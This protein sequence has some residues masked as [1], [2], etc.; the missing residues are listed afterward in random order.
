MGVPSNAVQAN[1]VGAVSDDELNTFL[2]VV[3]IVASA[4]NFVGVTN[5]AIILLG[6]V[7]PGDGGLGTFYWNA[8]STAA[9]D[10]GVTTI[11]PNGVTLGAWLRDVPSEVTN[12]AL[13]NGQ[14]ITWS[15]NTDGT[16]GT[17]AYIISVVDSLSDLQA[18]LFQ[19]TGPTFL[20]ASG[21]AS[22]QI[23]SV[24]S[25]VDGIT[26]TPSV[27]GS[28]PSIGVSG[29]DT[30]I[31]LNLKTKGTAPI[32][33][34]AAIRPFSALTNV[35]IMQTNQ[36]L[37]WVNSNNQETAAISNSSVN[38]AIQPLLEFTDTGAYFQAS[39]GTM[40]AMQELAS[41]VNY[42][43]AEP[44]IT[45]GSVIL[46]AQG[47]DTNINVL[48]QTQG[49]GNFEWADGNGVVMA[50]TF[51]VASSVNHLVFKPAPTGISPSLFV[52]GSDTNVGM[53]IQIK[54]SS[55][56]NFQTETGTNLAAIGN[57]ASAVNNILLDPAATGNTPIVWAVGTDTNVGLGLNTKGS[58]QVTINNDGPN[59]YP[60]QSTVGTGGG[61]SNIPTAPAT[62]M[63]ITVNGI[64]YVIPLF[65]PS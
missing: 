17:G 52:A 27:T 4:R 59:T 36:S 57:V 13:A 26:V 42:L 51:T 32:T 15:I 45:G 65:P 2:Q 37:S 19:D 22:F 10:G 21:H 20:G 6:F 11:V 40:F 60:H 41:A 48:F 62:Y 63:K 56:I 61:A 43:Q 38:T 44:A 39:G 1:G 5:M 8:T 34:Y 28:A 49:D 16:G 24:P 35:L 58:G 31:G 50:S 54:G 3:D 64:A 18:L 9:D 25:S 29:T 53:L 23:I 33:P 47:T 30:N 46:S 12:L 14:E 7:A 55:G